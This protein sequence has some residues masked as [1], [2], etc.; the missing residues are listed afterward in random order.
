M[1]RSFQMKL[2]LL[3]TLVSGIVLTLFG[4][5]LWHF[6]L[7]S[8]Q[9]RMDRDMAGLAHQLL[10]SG[11]SSLED[12]HLS[13]E[14][15]AIYG[16]ELESAATLLSDLH[17]H[18]IHQSA[19]WPAEVTAQVLPEA[20]K[21]DRTRLPDHGHG[22]HGAHE[23]HVVHDS[24][25]GGSMVKPQFK[26]VAR[27]G[28]KWRL[29]GLSDS[30]HTLHVALDLAIFNANLQHIRGV[31]L[32]AIS[33]ALSVSALGA[34]WVANRALRPVRVLT[35]M[36]ENVTATE[37]DQ[38]I[39]D[40]S[41]DL[42]FERLIR[43]FNEM[44]E[45]LDASFRQAVRFSADAS[46]ELKTP[47]TV[48]QGEVETALHDAPIGSDVQRTFASQ[49]EE[50]QRLNVLVD[51]LLL[52]SHADSGA[53]RPVRERF[54]FSELIRRVC[55]DIPALGPELTVECCVEG[56]VEL[57][58]D[59]DLIRQVVQNLVVNAVHYN[60]PGGWIRCELEMSHGQA[61]L[62]VGNS[63]A[64][65]PADQQGKIFRRFYRVDEARTGDHLGL[66]LSLALEIARVHGG[67]LV[68]LKSD[69]SGTVFEVTLPLVGC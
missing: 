42:E 59:Q 14:Q 41:V 11:S 16:E 10:V 24:H 8:N 22:D 45:R 35:E 48:M 2:A 33:A 54:D 50:I 19:N 27:E 66:G 30:S 38:R 7:S 1:I 32:L 5:G 28:R 62:R 63:G 65:I 23:D 29:V 49:L 17:Q 40:R 52:L 58:G 57:E 37:L 25:T 60:H 61:V 69:E 44:L 6:I 18:I 64:A 46:H 67:R 47:L 43:V 15:V 34:W 55:D 21:M 39:E 36:A 3:S 56:A 9:G 4:V 53:L 12:S 68:M 26:T 31:M 13:A 20:T 51:K